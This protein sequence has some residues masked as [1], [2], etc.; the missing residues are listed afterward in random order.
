MD[1]EAERTAWEASV[2][3]DLNPGLP[4]LKAQHNLLL[5]PQRISIL[6]KDRE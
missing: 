3:S 6:D 2:S 4:G 1:K 5:G